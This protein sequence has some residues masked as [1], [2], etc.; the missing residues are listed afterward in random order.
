VTDAVIR[1]AVLERDGYQCVRCGKHVGY[2]PH[3]IHHRILGN[4]KDMRASNLITLCGSGTTGCHGL[5]HA[6]PQAAMADGYIVSTFRKRQDTPGIPVMYA[7]TDVR[8]GG[9]FTLGDN[10]TLRAWDGDSLEA[11]DA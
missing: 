1:G 6:H 4:R 8:F 7:A 3:S 11:R 2:Q 9:R 10:M 5:V